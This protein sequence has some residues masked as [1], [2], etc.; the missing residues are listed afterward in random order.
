MKG[1]RTESH[2]TIKGWNFIGVDEVSGFQELAIIA[3][4]THDQL[5]PEYVKRIFH[6]EGV[7]NVDKSKHEV[8]LEPVSVKGWRIS[9]SITPSKEQA[10]ALASTLVADFTAADIRKVLGHVACVID[11]DTKEVTVWKVYGSNYGMNDS[12]FPFLDRELAHVQSGVTENHIRQHSGFRG[13]I[14]I[15][16]KSHE[17]RF[18]NF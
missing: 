4:I 8:H 1:T 15:D 18:Y 14:H 6:Y 2:V 13:P 11:G 3:A 17:I 12:D 7:V 9:G 16:E 10:D 5:H